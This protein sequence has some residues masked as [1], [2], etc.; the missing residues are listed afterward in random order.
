MPSGLVGVLVFLFGVAPGYLYRRAIWRRVP[1]EKKGGLTEAA[2]L[3]SAGAFASAIAVLV[4][5]GAAEFTTALLSL[6]NLTAGTDYLRA[7]PWQ[8]IWAGLSAVLLAAA[9]AWFAGTL[10]ATIRSR[11]ITLLDGTVWSR[12]LTRRHHERRP[13]LAVELLDGRIVEGFLLEVS[14]EPEMEKRDIALQ[15]P[16]AWSV[17]GG[18]RLHIREG[19][20]IVSGREIRVIQA[21]YPELRRRHPDGNSQESEPRHQASQGPR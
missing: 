21:S 19:F 18:S 12:V 3:I 16:I 6:E 15:P 7:H 20:V 14:T 5:L 13:F 17:P 1:H 10:T 4:V 11:D 2:E 8:A 9:L